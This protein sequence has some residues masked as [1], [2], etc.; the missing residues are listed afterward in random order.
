VEFI[1]TVVE[2]LMTYAIG[3]GAEYYDR[4]AIREILRESKPNDYR[5]S[6]VILAMVKS[7]PFQMRVEPAA[8]GTLSAENTRGA[9]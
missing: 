2:K 6:S 4:P 9:R 8:A 7:K 3:R 1:E 5:W